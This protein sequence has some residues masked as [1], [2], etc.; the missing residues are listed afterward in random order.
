MW[1]AVERAG[2][3]E[4]EAEAVLLQDGKVFWDRVMAPSG[5]KDGEDGGKLDAV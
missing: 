4:A 1:S 5:W 3:A 2:I